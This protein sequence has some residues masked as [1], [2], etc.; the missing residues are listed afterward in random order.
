MAIGSAIIML[1]GWAW[2]SVVMRTSP[3]LTL[4]ATVIKFIPGDI[5]KISLAA[6]VLHQGGNWCASNRA[7]TECGLPQSNSMN[8]APGTGLL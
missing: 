8:L 4:Y 7:K 1:S 6:A 2:F 3:L 5:I